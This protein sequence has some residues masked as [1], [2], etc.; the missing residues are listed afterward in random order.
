VADPHATDRER[1][2]TDRERRRADR[3]SHGRTIELQAPLNA[4]R[5]T[6]ILAS[7]ALPLGER[8]SGAVFPGRIDSHPPAAAEPS[9]R[10]E[11]RRSES[12]G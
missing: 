4:P 3:F 8:G 1:Y 9:E 10:S 12:S 7:R 11:S 5:A 2:A 6:R